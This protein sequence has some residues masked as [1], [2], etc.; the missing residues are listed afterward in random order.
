MK[1]NAVL[2]ALNISRL[3]NNRADRSITDEVKVLHAM[4]GKAGK[5]VKHRFNPDALA[6]INHAASQARHAHYFL[7]L[8]WEPGKRLLPLAQQA[9]YENEMKRFTDAFNA[10]VAEFVEDY[11]QHV[12]DARAMHGA[13][14]IEAEYPAKDVVASCFGITMDYFPVPTSTHFN[15]LLSGATLEKMRESLQAANDA[16]FQTA[17]AELWERIL[18][19]VQRMVAILGDAR[20]DCPTFRDSLFR[21]L[22]EVVAEAE[23][24]NVAGCSQVV[25]ALADIKRLA[26]NR[27]TPGEVEQIRE[28]AAARK[29]IVNEGKAI[30]RS[31]GAMAEGR[32]I[33][34]SEPEQADLE[35]TGYTS[36]RK[37]LF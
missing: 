21:N 1:L 11:E 22:D 16:R 8:A 13:K 27:T 30:L 7:T 14:F 9:R 10:A 24:L 33:S 20:E 18:A 34:A 35:T 36:K 4:T 2:V 17:T 32:T 12:A 25:A 28:S 26:K 15:E 37:F 31:F 5:W 29:T 6:R 19:P 3:P 23:P